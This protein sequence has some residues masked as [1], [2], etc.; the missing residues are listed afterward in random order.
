MRAVV[1]TGVSTG[2]GYSTAQVLIREGIRVFGSV[3]KADDARRLQQELGPNLTPLIFDVTDEGAV[4]S[5]AAYVREQLKGE[6]LFGLVNNAGIVVGGPLLHVTREELLTQLRVNVAGPLSVTQAFVPLLGADR[7][8]S[9]APGRIVNIGSVS[10]TLAVPFM[11]PYSI[12]KYGLEALTDTL[13]RELMLYG[14]D[15][16]LIGPGPVDTPIFDKM[17]VRARSEFDS[18][19]AKYQTLSGEQRGIALRPEQ[20]A[21]VVLASLT[22]ARPKARYTVVA[23]RVKAWVVVKLPGFMSKRG[24][25]RLFGK[26]LGLSPGAIVDVIPPTT[27]H[28]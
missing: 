16:I 15:V 1:V 23:N 13:R 2:I 24:V 5:A 6:R 3:R 22:A 9:G 4:K 28:S 7:G 25:D 26:M 17:V 8:L 21:E 18:A 14:I 19:M 27:L 11:G 12:S 20:V 10:G